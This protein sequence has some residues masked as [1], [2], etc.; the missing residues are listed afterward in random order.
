MASGIWNN[1]WC[2]CNRWGDLGLLLGEPLAVGDRW[3]DAGSRGDACGLGS[4][5]FL[6]L[7]ATKDLVEVVIGQNHE[8]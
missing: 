2:W 6:S 5:S 3:G 1:H 4:S 8:D 7:K